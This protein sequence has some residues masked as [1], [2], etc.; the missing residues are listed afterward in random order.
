MDIC[1]R[2]ES[3]WS[4]RCISHGITFSKSTRLTS[5]PWATPVMLHIDSTGSTTYCNTMYWMVLDVHK[6]NQFIITVE[7]RCIG[8]SWRIY[9]SIYLFIITFCAMM[10]QQS[11]KLSRSFEIQTKCTETIKGSHVTKNFLLLTEICTCLTIFHNNNLNC[12]YEE[13]N[14]NFQN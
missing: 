8:I 10:N 3:I 11:W 7:H 14:H 5:P 13:N 9:T 2:S 4:R 6:A 12:W 1:E